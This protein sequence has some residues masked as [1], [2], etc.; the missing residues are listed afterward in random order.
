MLLFDCVFKGVYVTLL[1]ALSVNSVSGQRA[2]AEIMSI[3]TE[4]SLVTWALDIPRHFQ[5]KL[6]T[7]S[8]RAL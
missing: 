1:L 5:M 7:L 3:S 2:L 4:E 8:S 6:C